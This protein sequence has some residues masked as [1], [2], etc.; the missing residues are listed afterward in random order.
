MHALDSLYDKE[1]ECAVL[2]ALMTE[3]TV[4]PGVETLLGVDA[5]VFMTTDH[6]LIYTAILAVY[7][8]VGTAEP[9]LVAND[10]QTRDELK[11]VGGADYLYQLQAPIVETDS[12]E[13][14]AEILFEKAQRRR[15]IASANKIVGIA[16]DETMSIPDVMAEC[17]E[18]IFNIGKTGINDG[19]EHVSI[20]IKKNI[21]S[22][23][24]ADGDA[25]RGLGTG[26][27]DFDE[28]TGGL[29]NGNL[30][31]I[32]ARPSMGKTSFALNIAQNVGIKQQKSVAIFTLEMPTPDITMRMLSAE[33]EIDYKRLETGKFPD[34]HWHNIIKCMTRV[35]ESPI[36]LKNCPAITAQSLR[37]Q[38]RRFKV[39]HPDLSLI[40][41][42]YM[43]LMRGGAAK[44]TTKDQEIGE[45][46]NT[47]KELALELDI[48]I[49]ACSQLNREVERRPDKRPKLSDIRESGR[50]E[51]DADIVAFLHRD[52]YYDDD[53]SIIDDRVEASLLIKKHRNGALGTVNLFFN[54]PQMRFENAYI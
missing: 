17:Q 31:I 38:S 29:K 10:L 16:N 36:Y 14:Y 52:D 18:M 23:Q 26:F 35:S 8:R 21:H 43:Q 32:A 48:P 9:I 11:R 40:I 2:G 50:I 51:Q 28:I 12:T 1:A 41:V 37:A 6:Q 45:I 5:T 42:D 20:P 34:E 53:D 4:I 44:Y 46:S 22:M 24:N 7:D 47:L 33:T 15:L 49:I 19:L 30:I 54:K 25:I 13:F 39:E 27:L 3:K